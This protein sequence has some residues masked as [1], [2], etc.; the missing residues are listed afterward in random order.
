MDILAMRRCVS[1]S[2]LT[3]DHAQ[4][5][6]IHELMLAARAHSARERTAA[7]LT[8][9]KL[10]DDYALRKYLFDHKVLDIFINQ[11]HRKDSSLLAAYALT[12]CLKHETMKQHINLDH[13]SKYIVNML[14]LDYFDDAVGQVEGFQVFGDLMKHDDLRKKITECNI[15]EYSITEVLKQKLRTGQPNE[16]RTSLICLDIFRSFGTYRMNSSMRH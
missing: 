3:L 8:L 11:L 7:T 10:C 6:L 13:L 5:K 16:I 4:E 1:F 14:R 12:I 9:L 2:A 15:A